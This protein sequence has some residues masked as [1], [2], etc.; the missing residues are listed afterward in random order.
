MVHQHHGCCQKNTATLHLPRV[1]RW[2]KPQCK[3]VGGP[4]PLYS[5]NHT[6]LLQHSVACWL[7]SSTQ[8][9]SL[10]SQKHSTKKSLAAPCPHWKTSPAQHERS[11]EKGQK[12]IRTRATTYFT[13]F[14][15]QGHVELL[16]QIYIMFCGKVFI[17]L[18]RMCWIAWFLNMHHPVEI[19]PITLDRTV[20]GHEVLS[21]LQNQICASVSGA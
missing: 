3:T 19:L 11:K 18:L 10:K 16:D 6:D 17:L 1:L 13:H 4:L 15:L 5:R 8:K 21:I 14:P 9:G 7:L 20:Q 2:K 12:R